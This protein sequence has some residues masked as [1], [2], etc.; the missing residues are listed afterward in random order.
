MKTQMQKCRMLRLKK[1][2]KIRHQIEAII[3]ETEAEVQVEM[4]TL[5]EIKTKALK[6]L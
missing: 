5:D 1:G 3:H 6:V 4:L 2:K